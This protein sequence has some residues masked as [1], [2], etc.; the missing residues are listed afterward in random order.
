[1]QNVKIITRSE[2]RLF[3]KKKILALESKLNQLETLCGK[4]KSWKVYRDIAYTQASLKKHM[5][6]LKRLEGARG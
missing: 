1:M 3:R 5:K 4:A 6:V 2:H